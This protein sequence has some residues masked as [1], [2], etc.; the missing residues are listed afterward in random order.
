MYLF[1]TI[2]HVHICNCVVLPAKCSHMNLFDGCCKPT[3]GVATL[4]HC[5]GKG[6]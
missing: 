2:V 6:S 4:T 3:Y 1:V 5:K